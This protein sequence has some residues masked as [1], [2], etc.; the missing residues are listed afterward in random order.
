MMSSKLFYEIFVMFHIDAMICHGHSIKME[1]VE[2]KATHSDG[3][4]GLISPYQ[5]TQWWIDVFFMYLF[6]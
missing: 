5:S 4:K 3:C 1:W 6:G 2:L